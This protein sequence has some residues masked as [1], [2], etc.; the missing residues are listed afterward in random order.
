M[1]RPSDTFLTAERQG[2]FRAEEGPVNRIKTFQ[3]SRRSV[4]IRAIH[5]C[6]KI[7]IMFILGLF[8]IL[9]VL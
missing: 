9:F 5:S 7:R 2:A 3:A 8:K 1:M 6:K 4:V